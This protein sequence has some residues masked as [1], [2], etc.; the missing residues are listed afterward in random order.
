MFGSIYAAVGAACTDMKE[1]Q[2]MLTPVTIITMLPLFVW[3]NVV[4]EPTSM[5]STL[6]SFFPP[7][8][9]MLMIARLAVPPGISLWQPLV[10]VVVVLAATVACVYI[11]GRIFRVGILLQGKA[12][13]V[14]ELLRWVIRG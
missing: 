7:A 3:L 1:A 6:A 14:G 2:A 5:F 9:P 10:G 12:P 11:S 8:T 13:R 4:R